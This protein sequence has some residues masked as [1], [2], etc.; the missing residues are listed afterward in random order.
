MIETIVMAIKMAT[1][2]FL[3]FVGLNSLAGKLD[4]RWARG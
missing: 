4:Q 2:N 1:I 3:R